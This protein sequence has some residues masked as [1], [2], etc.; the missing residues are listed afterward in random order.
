M[1]N[2]IRPH[3]QPAE[4]PEPEGSSLGRQNHQESLMSKGNKVRKKEVK[5]PKQDKKKTKK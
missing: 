4:A 1:P 2:T 3:D 5:K